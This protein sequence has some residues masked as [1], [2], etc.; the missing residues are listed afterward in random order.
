MLLPIQES[1]RAEKP[2]LDQRTRI[3]RRRGDTVEKECIITT[4]QSICLR[5]PNEVGDFLLLLDGTRTWA[6][7]Q[8]L[9]SSDR[10]SSLSYNDVNSV[11]SEFLSKYGLLAKA[12]SADGEALAVRPPQP[13]L[14]R[15]LQSSLRKLLQGASRC[16]ELPILLFASFFILLSLLNGTWFLHSH[17]DEEALDLTVPTILIALALAT[18]LSLFVHEFGHAAASH[19]VGVE[20][21]G[22]HFKRSGIVPVPYLRI[23]FYKDM[24]LGQKL[25]IDLGGVYF[26]ALLA[27][28]LFDLATAFSMPILALAAALTCVSMLSQ[29]LPVPH[30]DGYWALVDISGRNNILA[31]AF[32]WVK[33]IWNMGIGKETAAVYSLPQSPIII[34]VYALSLLGSAAIL[35][36]GG[37]VAITKAFLAPQAYLMV[38]T[39]P[40]HTRTFHSLNNRLMVWVLAFVI[41]ES[42]L[43]IGI[44]LFP[45]QLNLKDML[46][47]LFAS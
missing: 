45:A 8:M 17:Y 30:S 5:A 34:P 7:L 20:C 9:L 6:D 4:P 11:A 43:R 15:G 3:L 37:M 13:R 27:A 41:M 2:L 14:S 47:W 32:A 31:E 36:L 10:W 33:Q 26:E 16:Y 39:S 29:L 21:D 25:A 44:A 35:L 40:I 1:D 46:C 28:F 22:L 12:A 24:R 23:A 42:I 19:S 38:L 18:G